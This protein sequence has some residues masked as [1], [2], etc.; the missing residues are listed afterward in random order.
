MKS[1]KG[2]S[3]LSKSSV[4][5]CAVFEE[6]VIKG[7]IPMRDPTAERMRSTSSRATCAIGSVDAWRQAAGLGGG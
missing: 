6:G 2:L 5:G 3:F 4:Q 1:F 7:N